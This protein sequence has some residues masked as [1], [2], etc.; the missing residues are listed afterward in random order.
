[1]SSHE[2]N[3]ESQQS[4]FT[5]IYSL[6]GFLKTS[7]WTKYSRI[8]QINFVEDSFWKIEVI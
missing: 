3:L 7:Y 2:Y 4:Q 8:D 6:I 5:G 1:M